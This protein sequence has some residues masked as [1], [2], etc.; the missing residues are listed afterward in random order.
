M[1]DAPAFTE[2]RGATSCID[3]SPY[4]SPRTKSSPQQCQRV[5]PGA[6]CTT[7]GAFGGETMGTKSYLSFS[8]ESEFYVMIVSK[9][10]SMPEEM[11][12]VLDGIFELPSLSTGRA[13]ESRVRALGGR[14]S[15]GKKPNCLFLFR[16]CS[17]SRFK[18]SVYCFLERCR[19]YKNFRHLSEALVRIWIK[20]K[21][22]D[23]EVPFSH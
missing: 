5:S 6:I 8:K 10:Q 4:K 13:L 7:S 20:F 22:M 12:A 2:L 15:L 17:Q 19:F 18:N 1:E 14:L 3:S 23:I 11:Q 9:S 16:A 21:V